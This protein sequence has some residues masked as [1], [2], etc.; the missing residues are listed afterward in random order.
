M[1][2]SLPYDVLPET[3]PEIVVT[4]CAVFLGLVISVVTISSATTALQAL[5]GKKQLG[6]QKLGRLK[7]GYCRFLCIQCRFE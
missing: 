1:T 7:P 5:D 3:L 6:R 4:V 2:G